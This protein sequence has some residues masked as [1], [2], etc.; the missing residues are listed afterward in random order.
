[1][2]QAFD[3]YLHWLAIPAHFRP[4]S[5]YDLL[6]VPVFEARPDVIAA[7][8]EHRLLVLGPYF[9]GPYAA[10]AA[11]LKAEVENARTCLLNGQS[12]AVY[13]LWL[14]QRYAAT[15]AVAMPVAQPVG[16]G[17]S[18]SPQIAEGARPSVRATPRRKNRQER[19]LLVAGG[20]VCGVALVVVCAVSYHFASTSTATSGGRS[21]GVSSDPTR[22]A[23]AR[24]AIDVDR[25]TSKERPSSRRGSPPTNP[26]DRPPPVIPW[27]DD[28]PP[29]RPDPNTPLPPP[30]GAPDAVRREKFASAVDDVWSALRRHDWDEADSRHK[31]VEENAKD[32]DDQT[33]ETGLGLLIHYHRDFWSAVEKAVEGYKG[34]EEIKVGD[35]VIL[36]VEV[37]KDSVIIRDRGRNTTHPKRAIPARLAYAMAENWYRPDAAS[38][39]ALGAW[40]AVEPDGDPAEA[41]RLWTEAAAMGSEVS[42]LR[43]VLRDRPGMGE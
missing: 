13:D 29:M 31:G 34:N 22:P 15:S 19:T 14:R 9:A 39:L 42:P 2:N 33:I 32:T 5:H 36:I 25:R 30:E 43:A 11:R 3:P 26:D 27:E 4:P 37:T 10:W 8:A 12:K 20:I 7:S 21:P 18:A 1:M 17:Q 16:G 41:R 24:P 28:P 38:K 23:A 40:H 6:G 35:Q